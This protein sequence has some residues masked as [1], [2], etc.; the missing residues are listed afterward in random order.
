MRQSV[1]QHAPGGTMPG[2]IPIGGGSSTPGGGMSG[3]GRRPG[4]IP[5]G[6][7]SIGRAPAGS[8]KKHQAGSHLVAHI[9]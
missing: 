5:I 4:G 1:T 6:G 3:G 8:P 2:S 7:G 9:T